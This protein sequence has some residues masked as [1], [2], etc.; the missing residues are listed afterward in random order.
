MQAEAALGRFRAF[1]AER[2]LRLTRQREEVLRYCWSTHE[3]FTADEVWAWVRSRDRRVSRATVYR[4]LALLVEGGF[5]EKLERGRDEA[6]YEHVLGHRHHDH[7]ICLDCGRILE[8]R[9][10]EIERLQEEVARRHRFRMLRHQLRLEGYCSRCARRHG[11]PEAAEA[12][13]S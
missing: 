10:D 3:H 7:M 13:S 1:L 11:G 5:L 9:N 6:L 2:G 12:S 4:T 8:F